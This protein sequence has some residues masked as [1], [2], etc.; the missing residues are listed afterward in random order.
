[1]AELVK[2]VQQQVKNSWDEDSE[3]TTDVPAFV[4]GDR[5]PGL[6][7]ETL[8]NKPPTASE[9]IFYMFLNLVPVLTFWQPLRKKWQGVR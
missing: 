2:G 4:P 1:V 5:K 9:G 6:R 7:Q 8:D 3:V